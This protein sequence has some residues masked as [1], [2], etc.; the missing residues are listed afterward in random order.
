MVALTDYWYYGQIERILLHTCRLFMN[1]QVSIDKDSDGKDILKTVPC[2]PAFA[3]KTVAAMMVSNSDVFP[4]TAPKLIVQLT[5][6][7]LANERQMGPAYHPD[8]TTITERRFNEEIGN[9][10]DGRE[11]GMGSSFEI[12]RLNPIPLG[13]TIKLHILTTLY[14][15]KFQLFEQIRALFSP[16]NTLQVSENPLDWNRISA[17][18]LTDIDYS[19]KLANLQ[20]NELD[21][22][23]LTFKIDTNLDLPAEVTKMKSIIQQINTDINIY[24]QNLADEFGWTFDDSVRNI[25]TPTECSIKVSNNNTITLYD[26]YGIKTKQSWKEIFDIY[27]I[28]MYAKNAMMALLTNKDINIRSNDIRG[29]ITINKNNPTQLNF[30]IDP[31]SLPATTLNDI[32]DIIDPLISFPEIEGDDRNTGLPPAKLGQRYLII[33]DIASNTT[34]WG[35]IVNNEGIVAHAKENQI[36]E[37]MEHTIKQDDGSFKT[38]NAWTIVFD[39]TNLPGKPIVRCIADDLIKRIYTYN[40]DEKTWVDYI[41][42]YYQAGY[43]KIYLNN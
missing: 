20:S 32:N 1:F 42:S 12:T 33:S 8:K 18:T 37:Y 5:G 21:D 2:M 39:P 6:V 3:D 22:M 17:I 14:S 40:K 4:Q 15:Q 41:N 26:P 11:Q 23:V 36:I 28:P 7:H 43:F 25:F 31:D 9:Y 29:S 30:I 16:D 24:E 34:A 10:Y 35:V 27:K 38:F 19:S 13:L